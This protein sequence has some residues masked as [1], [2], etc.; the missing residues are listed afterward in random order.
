MGRGR[1]KTKHETRTQIFLYRSTHEKWNTARNSLNKTHNEFALFLLDIY[2]SNVENK[3]LRNEQ[4]VVSN[5]TTPVKEFYVKKMVTSTPLS[6]QTSLNKQHDI[7]TPYSKNL[8]EMECVNNE[9]V[10]NTLPY[11]DLS[12]VEIHDT[13][14]LSQ[15]FTEYSTVDEPLD[16]T[17]V[18]DVVSSDDEDDETE[19][20]EDKEDSSEASDGSECDFVLGPSIA[21]PLVF[22]DDEHATSEDDAGPS[23]S[24]NSVNVDDHPT[25]V[26]KSALHRL[27]NLSV[28][29]ECRECHVD[30]IFCKENIVGTSIRMNWVC[31]YGHKCASWESQ[32]ILRNGV[33]LADLKLSAAILLS[34]NNFEKIELMFRFIDLPLVSQS[35]HYRF[36]QKYFIPSIDTFWQ[37]VLSDNLNRALLQDIIFLGD[38]RMDSPGYCAKYCTYIGIDDFSKDILALEIIDKREVGLKSTLMEKEGF[39]RCIEHLEKRGINVKEVVTDAHTQISKLMREN[40]PDIKHSHDIWHGAKGLGK[41]LSAA[42]ETKENSDLKFW[43]K[44]I[45]KHFWYCVKV[46]N[47]YPDF[48]AKWKGVLHHTCGKHEWILGEGG[49]NS[50]DHSELDERS[51]KPK[52]KQGSASHQSLRR[53]VLNVRF[54]KSIPYFL[55]FRSNDVCENV[56]SLVLKYASKRIAHS[57]DAYKARNQLAALDYQMHKDRPLK[58]TKDGKIEYKRKFNKNSNRFTVYPAK[59]KK[60]YNYIKDL[61]QIIVNNFQSKLQISDHETFNPVLISPTIAPMPA[62]PTD[63][64]IAEHRS[65]FQ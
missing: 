31:I 26:F 23:D 9:T 55:N 64:L 41:K 21:E 7:S 38:G 63:F 54:L 62:P 4:D 35:S 56:N 46:T 42:S 22:S 52:L 15:V 2:S 13:D 11:D 53:V 6:I 57:Y 32:P 40:H 59:M 1:I 58:R 33:N 3:D 5:Q 44:D 16:P 14:D 39:K 60:D 27:A 18:P 10:E 20:A 65:R 47:S 17:Y 29:K 12:C 45:V 30:K 19:E 28:P 48:I 51:D 25:L 36:Q 49:K 24:K 43:I 61:M 34:G 8:F 37:N 50:C